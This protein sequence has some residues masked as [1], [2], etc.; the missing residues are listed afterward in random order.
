VRFAATRH[1]VP[2]AYEVYLKGM[3]CLIRL[4][5]EDLEVGM[6][7][8]E[9]ALEKD[10]DF[11]LAHAGVANFWCLQQVMG[12]LPPDETT[13]RFRAAARRAMDLD[14]TLA[15]VHYV[16]A[17]VKWFGW[18][19]QGAEEAFRRTIEINP[20]YGLAR[21]QYG[22]LLAILKRP[23]EAIV[24][25]QKAIELDPFNP[26]IMGLCGSTFSM[27]GRYDEGM[28]MAHKELRSSPNSSMGLQII[29]WGHHYKGEYDQAFEGAKAYFSAMGLAPVVHI[30]KE[31]YETGGY[32]EAMRCA[33]ETMA[34][35]S[36]DHYIQPYWIAILYAVAGEKDKCLDWLEKGY[37]TKDPM[38]AYFTELELRNMISDEPRY[39]ALLRKMDM[40]MGK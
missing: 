19:W 33:A 20:N 11:A 4:N 3:S 16:D 23:E 17:F 32:F 24:Q 5:P 35:A 36:Q 18:D 10:P 26:L 15:E 31:R 39:E 1:I 13:P 21:A 28:S 37:E 12:S 22:Q 2:E 14:P 40:P 7:Y 30:M 29:W 9:S 25:A 8:F 38:H 6:H 34:S 27:L